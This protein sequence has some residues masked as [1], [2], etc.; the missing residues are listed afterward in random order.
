[1]IK[2]FDTNKSFDEIISNVEE[3]CKESKFGVLKV[4]EFHNLLEEKGFPIEKKVTAFEICNPSYAK[5]LIE[6]NPDIANFMPCKITVIQ[7]GDNVKISILDI[8]TVAK[9]FNNP[10]IEEIAKEVQ[11]IINKIIEKL[12]K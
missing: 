3:V 8:F 9:T 10:K 4:Y 7:E 1:M 2:V 11:E 6:E 5:Q 12:S